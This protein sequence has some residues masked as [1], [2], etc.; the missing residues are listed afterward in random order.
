M[1][2]AISDDDLDAPLA[3]GQ[4]VFPPRACEAVLSSGCCD[5]CPPGVCYCD[6]SK[7]Y[8]VSII[9]WQQIKL[10]HPF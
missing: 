6:G 4:Q 7:Y 8:N 10:I 5:S 9:I 1:G 3:P 2:G